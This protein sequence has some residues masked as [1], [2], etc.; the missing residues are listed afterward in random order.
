MS[1]TESLASMTPDELIAVITAGLDADEQAALNAPRGPWRYER[2][3]FTVTNGGYPIAS[4]RHTS[5]LA[6]GSPLLDRT[7]EHMER[8]DPSRVLADVESKRKIVAGCKAT[9]DYAEGMSDLD[10]YGALGLAEETL[11]ALARPYLDQDTQ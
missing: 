2:E 3:R 11:V 5:S 7:G 9:L 8:F 10:H 1:A 6:D 4:W